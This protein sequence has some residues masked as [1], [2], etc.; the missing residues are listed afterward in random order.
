[1]LFSLHLYCISKPEHLLYGT[2]KKSESVIDNLEVAGQLIGPCGSGSKSVTETLI[3]GFNQSCPG[4]IASA[5]GAV[6]L[7]KLRYK[8]H[9]TSYFQNHPGLC[10][11]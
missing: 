2:I 1:M 7:P 10:M 5:F 8:K 9:K 11:P 6:Q 4:L 3:R